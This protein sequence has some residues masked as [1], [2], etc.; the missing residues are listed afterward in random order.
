MLLFFGADFISTHILRDA[1]TYLSLRVLA[2][3]LP[4]IAL[5][6]IFSGYFNAVRRVYKSASASITEQFVKIF[7]TVSLLAAIAPRGTEYACLALVVGTAASEALSFFYLLLFYIIDKKR[8]IKADEGKKSPDMRKRMLSISLPIALSSYLRSGLVTIEHILI[9]IGLRRHG[10]D[11]QTALASYGT[12]HGMVFPLILFPSAVCSTF[13]GL[14]VPE[15]SE[16]AAQYGEVRG[17]RHIC[18][19]VRRALCFALFFGIGTAGIFLCFAKPIGLLVYGSEEAA[20]YIGIFASLIPVMYL[21]TTVD[22][23]LKGLG[24]QFNSMIY[25]IIDASMS[26][27][28]VWTLMPKIGIYGYVICVF[29][30]ELVNLAFSLNRMLM[31]TDAKIPLCRIIGATSL[32]SLIMKLSFPASASYAAVTVV[33]ILLSLIFYVILLR[34]TQGLTKEDMTWLSGLVRE[35]KA[36]QLKT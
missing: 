9:P 33:G 31:V 1:R 28:L 15:L 29:L 10:S 24:Q 20:K 30:T 23:M 18:Y 19:I 17:N 4:F 12:I 2:I 32:S 26:V 11:Y 21:D 27:L 7:I 22:G 5:S 3:A 35:P 14:I 8:H 6:N 34:T 36:P 16:L 13:A 25:N